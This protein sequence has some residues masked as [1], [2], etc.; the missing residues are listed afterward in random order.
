MTT[1][2]GPPAS[3]IGRFPP[4]S[5]PS[6]GEPLAFT[7]RAPRNALLVGRHSRVTEVVALL[8]VGFSSS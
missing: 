1:R 5:A 2:W 4:L 3:L 8:R 6:T 7:F